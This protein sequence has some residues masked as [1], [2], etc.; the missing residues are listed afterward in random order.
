MQT[1]LKLAAA[2]AVLLCATAHAEENYPAE[3]QRAHDDC[4]QQQKTL[5]QVSQNDEFAANFNAACV[6][7]LI[8]GYAHN[9]KERA[10]IVKELDDSQK[11]SDD[12]SR[13]AIE[14]MHVRYL[15]SYDTGEAAANKAGK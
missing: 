7:G 9:V 14:T 3:M 4:T 2:L 11:S 12:Y 1:S 15:R 13:M 10:R 6:M 8:D 5:A